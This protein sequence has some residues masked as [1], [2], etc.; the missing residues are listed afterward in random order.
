M[1]I[2][3]W[4]M[5]SF[6]RITSCEIWSYIKTSLDQRQSFSNS[7]MRVSIILITICGTLFG[8]NGNFLRFTKTYTIDQLFF[9]LQL[10]QEI[11]MLIV[12]IVTSQGLF[13]SVATK[14]GLVLYLIKSTQYKKLASNAL[15]LTMQMT[16]KNETKSISDF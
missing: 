13:M 3:S 16:W 15:Q 11:V 7:S 9:S 14:M 12:S 5:N 4:V 8:E 6:H 1:R 10:Q 2:R